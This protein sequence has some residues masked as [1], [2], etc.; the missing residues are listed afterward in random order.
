MLWSDC[1]GIILI[2]SKLLRVPRTRKKE[3]KE[4]WKSTFCLFGAALCG[5]CFKQCCLVF[6]KFSWPIQPRVHTWAST[7]WE[8]R[9]KESLNSSMHHTDS[10]TG[11]VRNVYST[12]VCFPF[13]FIVKTN[14]PHLQKKKKSTYTV[15]VPFWDRITGFFVT[16][17]L[18]LNMAW[19]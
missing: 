16:S 3:I 1:S 5:C 11:V 17:A 7:D 12:S 9:V 13:P 15:P 4:Q 6:P 19:W 8:K 2:S 18:G 14:T 10:G